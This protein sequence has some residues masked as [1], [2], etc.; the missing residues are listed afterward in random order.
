VLVAQCGPAATASA[1]ALV[2]A[3][4]GR[5]I[6]LDRDFVE[7]ADV[8]RQSPFDEYDAEWNLPKAAAAEVRFR[9]FNRSV[10]VRGVVDDLRAEAL[11]PLVATADVVIDGTETLKEKLRLDAVCRAARVPW[12]MGFALGTRGLAMALE[13]GRTPCL[14]CLLQSRDAFR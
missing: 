8:R 7:R 6:V 1:E 3:G 9:R 13:W 2:R 10:D 12:V 11:R 14:R 4:I 5:L